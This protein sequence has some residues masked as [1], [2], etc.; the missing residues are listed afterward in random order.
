RLD[1]RFIE[2]VRL[3]TVVVGAPLERTATAAAATTVQEDVP[4]QSTERA[5]GR[6]GADATT[7]RA[8]RIVPRPLQPIQRAVLECTSY[9]AHPQRAAL[10]SCDSHRCNELA[11]KRTGVNQLAAL[12]DAVEVQ[13]A[14][15]RS[16]LQHQVVLLQCGDGRPRLMVP[17]DGAGHQHRQGGGRRPGTQLRRQQT[18]Q[19]VGD[20][21]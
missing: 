4:E 6:T 7:A 19:L 1:D 2:P 8:A 13:T 16:V 21:G 5:T 12:D 18:V 14:A 11:P 17:L 15:G 20:A 10:P 3:K 9:A